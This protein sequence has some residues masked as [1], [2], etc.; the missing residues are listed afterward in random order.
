MPGST[1]SLQWA[2]TWEG[3]SRQP[4]TAPTPLYQSVLHYF[5]HSYWFQYPCKWAFHTPGLS[6]PWSTLLVHSSVSWMPVSCPLSS[7]T[8]SSSTM[9]IFRGDLVFLHWH[10]SNWRDFY[11]YF[12]FYKLPN[13]IQAYFCFWLWWSNHDWTYP[14]TV[15]KEKAD[16]IYEATVLDIKQ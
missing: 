2:G 12:Y 13:L 3:A 7:Q 1:L 11:F 6:V 10:T 8:S 9:L 5:Y 15:N 14:L 16:E 4:S